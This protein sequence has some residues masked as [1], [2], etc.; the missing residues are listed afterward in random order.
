[1]FRKEKKM[2]QALAWFE[3]AVKLQDGDANLEIAKIYL[4]NKTDKAKIIHC[5]S[6]PSR[7]STSQKHRP[8]K[9][10]AY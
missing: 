9:P 8:T 1:V 3:R 7:P 10:V 5:Q 6:K 4:K 2:K